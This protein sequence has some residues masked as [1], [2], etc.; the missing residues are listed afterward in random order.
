[1]LYTGQCCRNRD[2]VTKVFPSL[3][4]E[5]GIVEGGDE[6]VEGEGGEGDEW[7]VFLLEEKA[8]V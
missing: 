4:D 8:R 1:V 6:G 7:E 3:R 2:L 5:R